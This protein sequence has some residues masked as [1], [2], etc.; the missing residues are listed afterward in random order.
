MPWHEHEVRA[1]IVP[2]LRYFE[3][4]STSRGFLELF[5]GSGGLTKAFSH[6][7]MNTFSPIDII[8][9]R[10]M[11]LLQKHVQDTVIRFL[12]SGHVWYVHLGTPCCF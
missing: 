1:P 4:R 11:D 9:S 6:F 5:S 7:G 10:N 2:A 3:H 12:E 8:F